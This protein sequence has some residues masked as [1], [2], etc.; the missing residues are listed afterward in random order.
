MYIF[1]KKKK[2]NIVQNIVDVLNFP[3]RLLF[4]FY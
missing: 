1:F 2:E 3:I 4:L